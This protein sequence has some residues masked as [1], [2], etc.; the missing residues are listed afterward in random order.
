MLSK[1]QNPPAVDTA[2]RSARS[3]LSPGAHRL[4]WSSAWD[5]AMR[6][7]GLLWTGFLLFTNVTRLITFIE[8]ESTPTVV[9]VTAVAA[10]VAFVTFLLLLVL[11]FVVRLRPLAKAPGLGARVVA[12]CGSFLPTFLGVLPRYEESVLLNLASFTCIAVGNGLSVY[13]FSYLNRSASIMAEARRLVT[14]G[15]YRFIR[16]PVYVFEEIAVVGALLTFVWPPL[17]ATF[18]LLIFAGHVWCQFQRMKNEEGVLE[19]TF[20][21]YSAY[22]KRTARLVPG[23][24]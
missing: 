10:R 14:T 16:H 7:I 15:P 11:V 17:V 3:E 24:Y 22:K 18:A 12:L 23:L 2:Q 9:F 5:I 6:G 4:I 20:P 21:E 8:V 1:K 13:G 19:A